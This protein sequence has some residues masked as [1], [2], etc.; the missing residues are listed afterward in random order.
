MENYRGVVYI[1]WQDGPIASTTSVINGN[2]VTLP[3]RDEG[4]Y[5]A[6]MPEYSL[7]ATGST[8]GEAINNLSSLYQYKFNNNTINNDIPKDYPE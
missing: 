8:F 4:Y 7:I 1:Y 5:V 3:I 2:P 6:C